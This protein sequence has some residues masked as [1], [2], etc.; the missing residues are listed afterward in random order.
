MQI[1]SA[2]LTSR[3]RTRAMSWRKQYLCVVGF[4]LWISMTSRYIWLT[5]VPLC[6]QFMYDILLFGRVATCWSFNRYFRSHPKSFRINHEVRLFSWLQWNP[7]LACRDLPVISHRT[8]L[9]FSP[10]H[11]LRLYREHSFSIRINDCGF[12]FPLAGGRGGDFESTI[13]H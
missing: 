5:T 2:A 3:V 9:F 7:C 6:L 11:Q 4:G 1:A 12:S 10:T 8:G 13:W